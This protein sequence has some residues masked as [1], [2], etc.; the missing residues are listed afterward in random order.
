VVHVDDGKAEFRQILTGIPGVDAYVLANLPP[1][2]GVST[3][4]RFPAMWSLGAAWSPKPEWTVEAD[5]NFHEWSVFNDLPIVF[6]KAPNPPNTNRVEDY[7]DSWQARTG[8]E[9][10]R[11]NLAYRAGYYFDK[12]PA[13]LYAVTPLLP[14]A[15]RHGLTLGLGWSLG[16][17]KRWTVDV[18]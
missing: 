9:Y 1:D 18:Y 11:G 17:D 7:E 5:F 16:T 4:L 8:A 12:S 10:R 6:E 15:D 13:L 14:D 2:Q 3:V